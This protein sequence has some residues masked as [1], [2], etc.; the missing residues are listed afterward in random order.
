MQLPQ[1]GRVASAIEQLS[2]RLQPVDQERVPNALAAGR[3]LAEDLIADRPSPALDV[4]AMD[5]YALRLQDELPATL[6]VQSTAPAGSAPQTLH[7]G[8]AIR[9]FTGAVVPTGADCVVRREDTIEHPGQVQLTIPIAEMKLG[10]NIRRQGENSSQGAKLLSRGS[11][12]EAA[13]IAAVASFGA[14]DL[15]VY[16]TVRVAVLNT[17]DELAEP[18][19]AVE[20]W[21]I[22]DSNGPTLAAWLSQLSWV[23]TTQRQRVADTLSSV[24]A[25]LAEQLEQSDAIILTGGV[26]MGDTDYV[27]A[28]IE[29]LGGEIVF[30]RLPIRPGKP[31]LGAVLKGKLILGLPGNPVSVAVT[32]RVLGE[33][34]L[35]KLAGCECAAPRL[36]V[37]LTESDG[38]RIDLTWFRLVNINAHGELHLAQSQGSGDLVSLSQSCGFVEIPPGENGQGPVRL[39]LW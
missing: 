14:R 9:I 12:V 29:S 23:T 16:R 22:R 24:Q 21:Q 37:Q 5:G 8:H 18:G 27:P 11:I 1:V 26:S 10:Q 4:S 31:V 7:P 34:L 39:T 32:A 30:H 38:K 33:P 28:A 13:S 20:A 25:A 19:A 6:P 17:G 35:R 36:S 15:R 3:V 2:T